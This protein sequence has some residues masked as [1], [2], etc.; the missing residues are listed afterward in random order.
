M[1]ARRRQLLCRRICLPGRPRRPRR[2][3]H[4]TEGDQ[5][6]KTGSPRTPASPRSAPSHLRDGA[7]AS[8]GRNGLRRRMDAQH[9]ASRRRGW[10]P[11]PTRCKQSQAKLQSRIQASQHQ[12]YYSRKWRCLRCTDTASKGRTKDWLTSSC[13]A[14]LAQQATCPA[15]TPPPT[16]KGDKRRPSGPDPPEP[17]PLLKRPSA[18]PEAS[19]DDEFEGQDPFDHGGDLEGPSD[20][21][22]VDCPPPKMAC[23][24]APWTIAVAAEDQGPLWA[25][26]TKARTKSG[27]LTRGAMA[28]TP[29]PS[30]L[31]PAILPRASTRGPELPAGPPTPPPRARP[32][33]PAVRKTPAGGS[34]VF[35][36]RPL[37]A[38][39]L[40]EGRARCTKAER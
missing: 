10:R 7:Q 22:A 24:M 3:R 34:T 11:P 6:R 9:A 17:A 31:L 16:S 29:R 20:D 33:A 38:R 4:P 36:V 13:S 27:R 5:R 23:F 8:E 39:A 12:P 19:E 14:H 30:S 26:S 28:T 32:P 25:P 37:L 2:R 1:A 35:L 40:H 21:E 18:P 15:E